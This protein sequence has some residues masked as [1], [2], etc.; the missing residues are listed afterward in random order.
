MDLRKERVF[1]MRKYLT[2]EQAKAEIALVGLKTRREYMHY[3]VSNNIKNLTPNPEVAYFYK[4]WS[5]YADFLGISQEEYE[6][7]KRTQPRFKTEKSIKVHKAKSTKQ[8]N[9]TV[10]KNVLEGLD[11]DKVIKFL[12]SEDVAPDTIVKMVAEMDIKSSTLMND[13]CKYMQDRS[14]RQAEVWRPTGYNTAEAQMS[15]KI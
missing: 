9:V 14:K 6:F 5:G 3:V 4:G 13:L 2:F 7:N 11:P 1:E 15:I 12:I 8:P 10:V